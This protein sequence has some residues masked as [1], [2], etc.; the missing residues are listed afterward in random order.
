M[1]DRKTNAFN[2]FETTLASSLG[3]TATSMS[4]VDATGLT[5]PFYVC[6]DYDDPAKREYMYCSLVSGTTLTVSE[7]YLA[8]S[9]LAS[10]ITH[11]SG[12]KVA[13]VVAA[14]YIADLHDRIDTI[15]DHGNLAGL[16]D[17]DHTQY[18]TAARADTWLGTKDTDDVAEGVTN[19]YFT[20]TRADTRADV[21]IP[22][23]A[24][25]VAAKT[26]ANTVTGNPHSLDASDVGA[27][28]ASHHGGTNVSDHP[29]ATGATRGFMS[30]AQF[31]KLNGIETGATADQTASEILTLIKTVDGPGSGLNADLF[32]NLGSTQFVRSDAADSASGLLTFSGGLRVTAGD[33]FVP[34]AGAHFN[35]DQDTGIERRSVGSGGAYLKADGQWIAIWTAGTSGLDPAFTPAADGT[36]KLGTSG[37]RWEE[38]FC[39]NGTINTS[40]PSLKRNMVYADLAFASKLVLGLPPVQY[41]WTN[42]SR[43]HWGFDAAKLGQLIDGEGR[44]F[45]GFIDPARGGEKGPLGYRPAEMLA[46]LWRFVQGIDA[47]LQTAGI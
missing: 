25:V 39:A 1:T 20:N 15:S 17:D 22:L 36:V 37:L 21:R 27:T 35:G 42:G 41:E 40:D 31:T 34:D 8:G 23:H 3:T 46:V 4:V 11:D 30:A 10:G 12:A 18:H 45:A 14:Q 32:D 28:G 13:V 43:P 38:L 2:A 7:R 44:D 29:E 16:G 6:V 19:L 24:D 33:M 5:H 47:R 26:H 9:A